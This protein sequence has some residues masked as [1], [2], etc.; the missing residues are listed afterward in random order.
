MAVGEPRPGT[1]RAERPHSGRVSE[2]ADGV[3]IRAV[4]LDLDGTMMAGAEPPSASLLER[5]S[6]LRERGVA[7]ILATGRSLAELG[8]FV[9]FGAFDAIV[10]ENGTV[11]VIDGEKSVLAP[12]SWLRVRNEFARVLGGG[13][14]EVVISLGR[15][16]LEAAKGVVKGRARIE[17]NKDRIM[18][19]PEGCDKGRGLVSALRRMGISGGVACVG[20]GENDLPMFEASD[21]AVALQNSVGILKDRADYIASRPDGEGAAEA[22]DVLLTGRTSPKSRRGRLLRRAD[23]APELDQHSGSHSSSSARPREVI[24]PGLEPRGPGSRQGREQPGGC[25]SGGSGAG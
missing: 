11:L 5:L 12:P 6:K 10:A 18:I 23:G 4:A 19:V 24:S 22:L 2:E 20:D 8:R 21:Y 13:T 14:E 7:V 3:G 1:A 25:E 17:L 16:M 9:D 15:E